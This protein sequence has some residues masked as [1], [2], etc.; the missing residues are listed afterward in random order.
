MKISNNNWP[1]ALVIAAM[2]LANSAPE[3]AA[4]SEYQWVPLYSWWNNDRKDNF[5]TTEEQWRA[6]QGTERR[7]YRMFGV[8]GLVLDP[9][10]FGPD[11]PPPSGTV[12]IYR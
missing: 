12:P 8:Q 3:A 1:F 11:N 9:D 10:Q 2:S 5:T 6:S 7:G 4:Q